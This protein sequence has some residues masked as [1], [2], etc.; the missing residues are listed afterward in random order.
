MTASNLHG[1]YCMQV[2][3]KT[4]I[5]DEILAA[6]D[7]A[8]LTVVDAALSTTVTRYTFIICS[9]EFVN[10]IA[11]ASSGVKLFSLTFLVL[12]LM[13]FAAMNG[14]CWFSYCCSA[15]SSWRRK[16]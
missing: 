6:A 7:E 10:C 13:R 2:L 11:G 1:S 4:G 3:A 12:Y 9:S 8:A 14:S 15:E 5:D 16:R